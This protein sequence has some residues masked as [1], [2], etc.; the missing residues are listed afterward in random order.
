M[1]SAADETIEELRSSIKET[2]IGNYDPDEIPTV[3]EFNET[4]SN[5]DKVIEI[6]RRVNND[7]LGDGIAQTQ[8]T[9]LF[10]FTD[11]DS[12][13]YEIEFDKLY[14]AVEDYDLEKLAINDEEIAPLLA[15]ADRITVAAAAA[16][17][18]AAPAGP[19]AKYDFYAN[20]APTADKIIK[21]LKIL[22]VADSIHDF[23][24][25][26]RLRKDPGAAEAIKSKLCGIFYKGVERILCPGDKKAAPENVKTLIN[27]NLKTSLSAEDAA[28]FP[29][30]YVNISEVEDTI[31]NFFNEYTPYLE[32]LNPNNV[33]RHDEIYG[34]FPAGP[35]AAI[36]FD[37]EPFTRILTENTCMITPSKNK[38]IK[39]FTADERKIVGEF[40]LQF[41]FGPRDKVVEFTCDTAPGKVGQIFQDF[42][43]VCALITQLNIADSATS[44]VGQKIGKG[45]TQFTFVA[46]EPNPIFISTRNILTKDTYTIS[47][48]DEGFSEKKPYGFKMKINAGALS[49]EV[50]FGGNYVQG[51]SLNYLLEATLALSAD[52]KAA[53]RAKDIR[54]ALKRI[55]QQSGCMRFDGLGDA[56]LNKIYDDIH[57]NISIWQE[58][59]RNGDQ[60]QCDAA[61]YLFQKGRNVVLVT[62]DRPCFLLARL[63]GIPCIL[64]YKDT[65]ILSKNML[66]RTPPTPEEI[67]KFNREKKIKFVNNYSQLYKNI[68]LS[69][70]FV[71]QF[72]RSINPAEASGDIIS[73]KNKAGIFNVILQKRLE[74]IIL[75]LR[76]ILECISEIRALPPL[77]KTANDAANL[78]F[79]VRNIY[80][81]FDICKRREINIEELI[82]IMKLKDSGAAAAAVSFDIKTEYDIFNFS[83][84]SYTDLFSSFIVIKN[85]I[86]KSI[87]R[88]NYIDYFSELNG[89]NGYHTLLTDI[90]KSFKNSEIGESII[91]EYKLTDDA[92]DIKIKNNS[93]NIQ[94]Y[95]EAIAARRAEKSSTA[96]VL[97]PLNEAIAATKG[98]AE[99]SFGEA[100]ALLQSKIRTAIFA[101]AGGGAYQKGGAL[102][103]RNPQMEKIRADIFEIFKI[104]CGNAASFINNYFSTKYPDHLELYALTKYIKDR[105]DD[106]KTQDNLLL[107]KSI[108]ITVDTRLVSADSIIN[109][110]YKIA[111]QKTKPIRIQTFVSD[112]IMDIDINPFL[113]SLNTLWKFEITNLINNIDDD[114]GP[115]DFLN[116]MYIL[117]DPFISPRAG[118]AGADLSQSTTGPIKARLD[119]IGLHPGHPFYSYKAKEENVRFEGIQIEPT[120]KPVSLITLTIIND[121]LNQN[122]GNSS[123][124]FF[125]SVFGRAFPKVDDFEPIAGWTKIGRII[126][127]LV[128]SIAGNSTKFAAAAL[129]GGKRNT[130]KSNRS[131]V[132]RRSNKNKTHKNSIKKRRTMR[133]RD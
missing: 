56:L 118:G 14:Q 59:K 96:A 121:I 131:T 1:A 84:S 11:D 114:I 81:F 48:I 34:L 7:S 90:C 119:S 108:G 89:T 88:N 123:S 64:H 38:R 35:P 97:G 49:G 41:L 65:F 103:D 87:S 28:K 132:R 22:G 66:A 127:N 32:W 105:S 58:I 19:L 24:G 77:Q 29:E 122:Y 101:V 85:N 133:R 60:D 71:D 18:P 126:T 54:T 20:I 130:R 10:K 12:D 95:E 5:I 67:E 50:P 27:N 73:K 70:E 68:Q 79:N 99:R 113:E 100:Q 116:I 13:E 124:Y 40:I 53:E 51:A 37:T 31:K 4:N 102:L 46:T 120:V 26:Y 112:F 16:P 15:E 93:V 55:P 17:A 33:I 69:L 115:D 25:G 6:S 111:L 52:F 94:Q 106:D 9:E 39:N 78:E 44:S 74:D 61:A 109:R 43:D 129:M 98:V 117:L 110:K 8:I 75:Y 30:N 128:I 47:Y 62:I 63:L 86:Q 83:L 45:K 42:D 92:E 107:L 104:I 2:L 82:E 125:K 57:Q 91:Q 80:S 76:K 21:K 3:V 72:I 36:T 23:W